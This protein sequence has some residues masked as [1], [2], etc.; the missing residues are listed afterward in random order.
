M[1]F[2][3]GSQ[4]LEE[5]GYIIVGIGNRLECTVCGSTS[6]KQM[7]RK[8]LSSAGECAGMPPAFNLPISR[9]TDLVSI[10][11][12]SLVVNGRQVH[13]SHS[14]AWKRGVLFCRVCGY[15]SV[16]KIVRLHDRCPMKVPSKAIGRHLTGID[17]GKPPTSSRRWPLD[18]GID[19]TRAIAKFL[20]PE[21]WV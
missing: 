1:L 4:T 9:D 10:R 6:P 20:T 19:P 13:P 2:L 14:L 5:R 21:E 3:E 7:S 15:H 8:L 16:K 17:R 12:S 11:T 18:D